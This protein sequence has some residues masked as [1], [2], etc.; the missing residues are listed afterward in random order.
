MSRV[1]SHAAVRRRAARDVGSLEAPATLPLDDALLQKHLPTYFK[2]AAHTRAVP[3]A[4]EFLGVGDADNPAIQDYALMLAQLKYE[5][6][7][8]GGT[9]AGN[10]VFNALN[11]IDLPYRV[12]SSGEM[13]SSAGFMLAA[14]ADVLVDRKPGAPSIEMPLRWPAVTAPQAA[15]IAARSAARWPRASPRPASWAS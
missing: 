3:K 9:P 6:E 10:A 14:A 4:G 12:G 1:E 11:Q 15:A 13:T 5:F 2:A 8:F 7:A